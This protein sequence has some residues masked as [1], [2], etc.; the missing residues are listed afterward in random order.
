[1]QAPCVFLR[2]PRFFGRWFQRPRQWSF[3]SLVFL[4]ELVLSSGCQPAG[5]R[6]PIT[7]ERQTDSINAV[8]FA[9]DGRTL[10][11]ASTDRTVRLSGMSPRARSGAP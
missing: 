2:P 1:M 3:V 5:V 8:S 10:A 9:P 6:K 4:V 7:L 11:V